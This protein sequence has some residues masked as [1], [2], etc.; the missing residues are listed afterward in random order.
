MAGRKPKPTELKVL[1]GNPGKRKLNTEAPKAPA[2]DDDTPPD[3]LDK[4]AMEEWKRVIPGLRKTGVLTTVDVMCLAAYCQS[5][6]RWYEAEKVIAKNG[7]TYSG[8]TKNG[9]EIIRKNPNVD[10]AKQAMHE[11]RAFAS[12]LGITPA[13]R[14]RVN[15]KQ[16]DKKKSA[17]DLD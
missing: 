16:A 17:W 13:S 1:Q 8:Y 9:D 7:T 6:S 14:A 2:L 10:I 5:Y 12:E 15:G 3:I 11:M 4:K